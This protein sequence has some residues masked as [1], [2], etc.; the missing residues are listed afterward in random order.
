M[1]FSCGFIKGNI[2]VNLKSSSS[3]LERVDE[4]MDHF[5]RI[6]GIVSRASKRKLLQKMRYANNAPNCCMLFFDK[7]DADIVADTV[8]THLIDPDSPD[9]SF[10]IKA[11]IKMITQAQGVRL[12]DIPAGQRTICDMCFDEASFKLVNEKI[13]VTDNWYE[14][15]DKEYILSTTARPVIR[16]K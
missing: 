2:L 15:H 3:P 9:H 13:P 6:K 16:D 7:A 8:F 4:V 5:L 12:E 14:R 11:S 1:G 10:P